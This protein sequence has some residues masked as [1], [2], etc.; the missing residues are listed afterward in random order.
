MRRLFSYGLGMTTPWPQQVS[1]HLTGQDERIRSDSLVPQ[2]GAV[3]SV[4]K[5]RMVLFV[6]AEYAR[7]GRAER[8]AVG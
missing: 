8:R 4:V 5:S 6:K 3:T 7:A 1:L 2:Y